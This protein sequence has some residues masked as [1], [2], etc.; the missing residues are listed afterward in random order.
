MGA[1][2]KSLLA[3][4][5]SQISEV[6]VHQVNEMLAR[7][8]P[9]QLVDVR[10]RDEF[11][12]GYIPGAR[13]I[14]RGYLELR[15]DAV[16][17]ERDAP[18]DVYCA[19][20]SRSA[21]AALTLQQLGYSNVKSMAGG[22]TEWKRANYPFEIPRVFDDLQKERYSRH[23]MIPEVGEAGQLK[24]LDSKVLVIGAGGLGSPS[25]V[26]L[27]A[28]GVGNIGIVDS[29]LVDRS[30]L[31]R[32]ILHW[33]S[34]VGMPKTE[35][36]RRTISEINPDVKVKTYQERL[37]TRNVLDVIRDYD[38]VIDGCDNF[39]TRYM[40]NDACV[41]AGKPNIYGS[42]FRFEGQMSVFIPGRGPCYRCLYPVP[43]PAELAP[44]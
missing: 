16:I 28:A 19:G 18:V 21:L 38:V 15:I 14:P 36:A 9:V 10:E 31:Q 26:Y 32:Q 29:D 12:Q 11:N 44:T 17:P 23:L 24:L 13:F 39:P 3:R 40:V 2:G 30:N 33:T 6:N 27:A 25:A 20:G 41:I 42:I 43:T 35:S 1:I 5:R 22:F 34:S 8:E 7:G 4:T 37:S